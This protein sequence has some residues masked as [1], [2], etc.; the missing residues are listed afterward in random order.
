MPP[1]KHLLIG[2]GLIVGIIASVFC[3]RLWQRGDI[4]PALGGNPEAYARATG[5][6]MTPSGIIPAASFSDGPGRIS[7]SA[8]VALVGQTNTACELLLGK[9]DRVAGAG[10]A[11]PIA[12]WWNAVTPEHADPLQPPVFHLR[13]DLAAD[14]T[15]VRASCLG[16]RLVEISAT[17]R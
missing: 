12:L 4:D 6:L 13:L 17:P 16:S 10:G 1:T 8:A 5:V 9:P 15:V 7:F 3:L 2:T 14:G 11:H